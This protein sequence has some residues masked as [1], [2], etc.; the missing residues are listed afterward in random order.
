MKSLSIIPI[1]AILLITGCKKESSGPKVYLLSKVTYVN[2]VQPTFAFHDTYAYDSQNRVV[3]VSSDMV[4]KI[5]KYTY[6]NNNN[7]VTI[8][9][10]STINGGL[11]QTDKWTYSGNTISA[12]ILDFNNNPSGSYTIT[13]DATKRVQSISTSQ[14]YTQYNYDSSG[15]VIAYSDAVSGGGTYNYNYTYDNKK[16]PLSMTNAP[17]LHL[18]YLMFYEPRTNVNNV[19]TESHVNI[20]MTYA[21]NTAGLP[22]SAIEVTPP[23]PGFV[24]DTV[25]MSFEYIIK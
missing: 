10:F 22:V 1:V 15:N 5:C 2:S 21:Y 17:N 12:Q 9:T 18:N 24:S 19:L 6:D 3:E 23:V 16:A 20:T 14:D 4:A 25:K 11:E 7:L 13:L 8:Q